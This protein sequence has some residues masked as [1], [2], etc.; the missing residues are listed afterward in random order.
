MTAGHL[1]AVVLVSTGTSIVVAAALAA[2]LAPDRYARLH[3]VTPITSL[4][5]PLIA[6]GLSVDHGA[7]LTTASILL[8][9][10]LLFIAGPILSAAISRVAAQR[11][12]RTDLK[13]P[14]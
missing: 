5:G 14:Q 4:G 2:L 13:E 10:A 9:T 12:G 1:A 7:G 11:D 3:L 8:P 6:V